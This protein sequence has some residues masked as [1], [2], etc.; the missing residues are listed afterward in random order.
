ML[1]LPRLP[2]TLVVL[3]SHRVSE[4]ITIIDLF[5]SMQ[6]DKTPVSQENL[7]NALAGSSPLLLAAHP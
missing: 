1:S 3:V 4:F 7:L 5:I 2:Q 6:M